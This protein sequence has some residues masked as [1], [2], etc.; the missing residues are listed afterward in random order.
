M[1]R[2]ITALALVALT[3]CATIAH[4]HCM[5]I[6]CA[7]EP[8]EQCDDAKDIVKICTEDR[9][10]YYRSVAGWFAGAFDGLIQIGK[11]VVL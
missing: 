8:A 6:Y 5:G 3:S 7:D 1:S 11:A 2:I 9:V 10:E 4:H